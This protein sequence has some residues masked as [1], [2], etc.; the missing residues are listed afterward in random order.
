MT[1]I[2]VSTATPAVTDF[3]FPNAEQ[4]DE[5]KIKVKRGWVNDHK[6][7]WSNEKA[8]NGLMGGDVD[9]FCHRSFNVFAV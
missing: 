5:K 6:R 3:G 8:K 9:C 2:A 7:R 1:A 4:N